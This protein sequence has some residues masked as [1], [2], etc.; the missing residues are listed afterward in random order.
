MTPTR[1]SSLAGEVTVE[2]EAEDGKRRLATLTPG[3]AFGEV[4]LAGVPLRPVSVRGESDGECLALS[5]T[6]FERLAAHHPD[7]QAALMRNLLAS[8]YETIGRMSR[9]VGVHFDG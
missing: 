8:F 2:V 9:E 1:P 4:A 5:V 3:L 6:D 7:L